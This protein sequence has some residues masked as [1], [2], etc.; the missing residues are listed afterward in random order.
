MQG[1]KVNPGGE[2][3]HEVP[4]S[5]EEVAVAPTFVDSAIFSHYCCT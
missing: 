5:L 1:E 4:P 3:F 2:F